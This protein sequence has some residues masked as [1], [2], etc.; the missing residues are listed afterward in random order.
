[1]FQELYVAPV[2]AN[3]VYENFAQDNKHY[4]QYVELK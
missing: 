1:M 4:P 3:Y 2:C